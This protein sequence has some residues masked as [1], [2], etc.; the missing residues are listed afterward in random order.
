M[1][2]IDFIT[3]FGRLLR[4]GRLREAFALD[5]RALA[6]EMHLC[7][8]D[9]AAWVQLVP[10]DVEVQAQVLLRKRLDQIAHLIPETTRRLGRNLWPEFL[11]CARNYWPGGRLP[12]ADDALRFCQWLRGR[13]ADAVSK[14]EWNRIQFL[15]SGRRMAIFWISKDTVADSGSPGHG[16]GY[17]RCP[18]LQIL[19]RRQAN[20]RLELAF[21]FGL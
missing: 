2:E 17:Y 5:S 18:R 19:Y 13:D 21:S 1:T 8:G 9:L 14:A 4:D 6:A 15:L 11:G 10:G 3:A 12:V 16:R 20:R 7:A